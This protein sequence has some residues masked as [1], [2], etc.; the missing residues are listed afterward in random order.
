MLKLTLI[1]NIGKD[2]QLKEVNGQN[3]ISFTVAINDSYYNN[4]GTKV[5]RMD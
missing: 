4:E 2:A 5:E 3:C 1:G